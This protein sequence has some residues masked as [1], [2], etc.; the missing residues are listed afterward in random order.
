M[1]LVPRRDQKS[2]SEGEDCKRTKSANC[3]DE[4]QAPFRLPRVAAEPVRRWCT[5]GA[6]K[7]A[8]QVRRLH[9]RLVSDRVNAACCRPCAAPRT[10][11]GLRSRLDGPRLVAGDQLLQVAR[12]AF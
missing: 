5:N 6:Q 7:S 2:L 1:G 9:V 11:R 12:P 8:E 10:E 3:H 4:E